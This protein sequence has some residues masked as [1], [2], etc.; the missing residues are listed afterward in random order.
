MRV[1]SASYYDCMNHD[2][3]V[4]R[5]LHFNATVERVV[6]WD[7]EGS[8]RFLKEQKRL[9]R[10][11]DEGANRGVV[12]KRYVAMRK[13]MRFKDDYWCGWTAYE[14]EMGEGEPVDGL[15]HDE[16]SYGQ[17]HVAYSV[18]LDGEFVEFVDDRMIA[19]QRAGEVEVDANARRA[20]FSPPRRCVVRQHRFGDGVRL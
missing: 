17:A 6:R 13:G 3:F 1:W 18:A 7:H 10:A 15:D 14:H 2:I 11:L 8:E 5:F 9:V 12:W 16:F 4:E 20:P 19:T